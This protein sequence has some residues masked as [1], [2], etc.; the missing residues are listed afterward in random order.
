[1]AKHGSFSLPFFMLAWLLL[2]WTGVDS[3]ESGPCF[4]NP[5]KFP[6]VCLTPII[7]PDASRFPHVHY[8]LYMI[9]Q[10]KMWESCGNHVG[11]GIVPFSYKHIYARICLL[12][13]T[14]YKG[15][16]TNT[17]ADSGSRIF[18]IVSARPIFYCFTL[19]IPRRRWGSD[20]KKIPRRRWG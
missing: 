1:M 10:G 13:L 6:P 16:S 3:G 8:Q 15:C 9:G 14:L 18:V 2:T 5:K 20:P 4:C 11:I 7:V 12:L 17:R 19:K